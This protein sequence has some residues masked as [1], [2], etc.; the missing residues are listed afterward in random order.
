MIKFSFSSMAL[1]DHSISEIAY[2]AA[3]TGY[4]GIE[5]VCSEHGHINEET[6]IMEIRKTK[7]IVEDNGLKIFSIAGYARFTSIHKKIREDN[8]DKLCRHVEFA[9]ELGASC[10]RSLGGNVPI[11]EWD[12]APDKYVEMLGS[13]LRKAAEKTDGSG[14]YILQSTHDNFS[15]AKIAA[16]VIKI[17]AHPSVSLLWCVIHPLQYGEP[18]TT[19][20]EHI[21]G[22]FRLV[23]F[24]DAIKGELYQY[25]PLRRLGAG[26]LPLTVIARLLIKAK[27][28]GPVSIEWEKHTHPEIEN[29]E[30]VLTHGIKYLK[31]IFQSGYR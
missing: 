24:K 4:D 2:F 11:D 23:H 28:E 9:R 21:C 10:V 7:K 15:P 6:R 12:K 25:W 30:A 13:Y 19:T 14:V 8:L 27:Y 22:K 26:D 20:W 17:A 16:K 29:S 3:K 18:L 1:L 5:L 31:D